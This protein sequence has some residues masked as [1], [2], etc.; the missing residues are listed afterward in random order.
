MINT[1]ARLGQSID[2]YYRVNEKA[3]SQHNTHAS[4]PSSHQLCHT[5]SDSCSDLDRKGPLQAD[6]L[7]V[8][9][10]CPCRA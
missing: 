8:L 4:A 10:I 5:A 3:H 9:H 7:E 2:D 6:S 1:V